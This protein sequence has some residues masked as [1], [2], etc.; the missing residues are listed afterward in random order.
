MVRLPAALEKKLKEALP[1]A[2]EREEFVADVVEKALALYRPEEVRPKAVGGTLHLYTD[3]GARGNPGKAAVGCVLIDPESGAVLE[4]YKEAIGTATNNIA[5]YTALIRGLKLATKYRP[6]HLICHLDSE[7]VVKQLKGEYR[8]K[9]K[10]FTPLIESITE[11]IKEF[12]TVSF[13]AIPRE[14]NL[15]ADR[16][17]NEALD[18]LE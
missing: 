17:L 8:V 9:M 13:V 18:A 3:G 2:R 16:L 4:D 7:L 12:P 10:T 1:R 15:R 14:K 5:E 11:L 6:N